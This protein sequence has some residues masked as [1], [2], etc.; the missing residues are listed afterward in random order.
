[1]L[2]LIVGFV[3]NNTVTMLTLQRVREFG[4]LRAIGGSR[5][6]VLSLVLLESG[7]STVLFG[8]LGAALAGWVLHLLGKSGIPSP[9][10]ALDF[11]FGGVRL[12]P[13]LSGG[14][15]LLALA[16]VIGVGI[17]ASLYPAVLATRVAPLVAM[18]S[19]D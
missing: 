18:Q 10:A 8:G 16:A 11:I 5:R 6:F 17:A 2:F 4:T 1:V 12:H 7:L 3:L 9:D 15:F 14:P 19:E 13:S